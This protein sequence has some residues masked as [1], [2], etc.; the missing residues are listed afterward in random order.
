M[1]FPTETTN[2]DFALIL[3]DPL[4]QRNSALKGVSQS[5]PEEVERDETLL[6]QTI[7]KLVKLGIAYFSK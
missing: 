5:W 6:N 7:T 1:T 3:K 2:F 4:L